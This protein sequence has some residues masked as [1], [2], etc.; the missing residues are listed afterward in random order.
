[1]ILFLLKD[2]DG[3]I[4]QHVSLH[5]S[6]EVQRGIWDAAQDV[7]KTTHPGSGFMQWIL[8][9]FHWT[10]ALVQDYKKLHNTVNGP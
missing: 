8:H 6:S 2:T 7:Q 4:I 9:P 3:L 1:M 10:T 5:Y